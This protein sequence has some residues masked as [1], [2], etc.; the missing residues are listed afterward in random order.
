MCNLDELKVRRFHKNG[1]L[2]I[3]LLIPHWKFALRL[4]FSPCRH[5]SSNL[6]RIK[7]SF[8]FRLICVEYSNYPISFVSCF[9]MHCSFSG[10]LLLAKKQ[11]TSFRVWL[12][13]NTLGVHLCLLYSLHRYSLCNGNFYISC[14]KLCVH[15]Y[16]LNF[17]G[18]SLCFTCWPFS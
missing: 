9:E 13:K 18:D 2:F 8:N 16:F 12:Y 17:S 4:C 3:V 6:S 11:K 5:S 14:S 15:H 1:Y 10:Y 7:K